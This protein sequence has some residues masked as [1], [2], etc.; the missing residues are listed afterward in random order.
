M[1][2]IGH[3]YDAHVFAENRALVLGGVRIPFE[4]GLLGHSDADVLVH[5]VID[6]LL[7]AAALGDIGGLFPDT[8]KKYENISSLLLLEETVSLLE[9]N[10]CTINNID[11]TIILLKP[12]ISA[13]TDEMRR[14][15]ASRCKIPAQN[16][17]VK[18]TTEEG[19]GLGKDA[20]GAHCVCLI[21]KN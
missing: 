2:R 6:A 11:C 3:G 18:A 9:K 5:A 17:S 10:G 7:G 21:E 14:N 12:K 4:K 20:A 19:K 15:I 13:Y 16:V 1:L 8:D